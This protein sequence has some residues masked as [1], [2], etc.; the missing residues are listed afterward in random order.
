MG[1]SERLSGFVTTLKRHKVAA[2]SAGLA[3]L[4]AG[5]AVLSGCGPRN[6]GETSQTPQVE[7]PTQPVTI[8]SIPSASATIEDFTHT[9]TPAETPTQESRTPVPEQT[10]V[11]SENFPQ[12][13]DDDP[14]RFTVVDGSALEHLRVY[15]GN[16]YNILDSKTGETIHDAVGLIEAVGMLSEDNPADKNRARALVQALVPGLLSDSEV[17]DLISQF[18]SPLDAIRPTEGLKITASGI[19]VDAW[20]A[21]NN[22]CKTSFGGGPF[23]FDPREV[24]HYRVVVELPTVG[25]QLPPEF[26]QEGGPSPVGSAGNDGYI[27]GPDFVLP[28]DRKDVC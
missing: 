2:G 21:T 8:T 6:S 3:S 28:T 9:P 24:K 5:A 18:G 19:N 22:G 16:F 15:K 25:G 20:V 23:V 4:A 1:N 17:D 7:T 27:V 11:T 14:L 13:L 12:F 26:K 10:E